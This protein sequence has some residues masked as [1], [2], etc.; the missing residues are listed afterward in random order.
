M[1]IDNDDDDDNDDTPFDVQQPNSARWGRGACFR[2]SS[3]P[4]CILDWCVARFVSDSW[5]SCF[6]YT[7]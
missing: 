2:T 3:I 5:V 6:S 7:M 4:L 1:L